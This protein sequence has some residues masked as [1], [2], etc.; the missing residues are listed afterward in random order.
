MDVVAE[1][2]N[3]KAEI[4]MQDPS[5]N[6]G[7]LTIKQSVQLFETHPTHDAILKWMTRG[8]HNKKVPKGQGDR[9]KLKSIRN[10]AAWLTRIEW[11]QEFKVA[12]QGNHK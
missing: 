9:I 8:M 10:G 3:R 6:G 1:I 4:E 2:H 5:K 7:W 11:I 12:C